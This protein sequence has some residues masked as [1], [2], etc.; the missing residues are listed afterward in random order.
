MRLLKNKTAKLSLVLFLSTL[1]TACGFHLR[2]E[3]NVP[4]DIK[5]ISV[6]SFDPY[7]KITRLVKEQLRL[8]KIEIVK[9]QPDVPNLHITGESIS[10]RTLSLYQNT[11]AAE[12][13]LTYIVTY[14]VTVPGLGP[15]T[16]LRKSHVVT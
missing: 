7:G 16:S 5:E 6:T 14:R 15:K 8:S 1:L 11:R 4:E 2:G 13:E 9:P 10:D 3:Y 12:K